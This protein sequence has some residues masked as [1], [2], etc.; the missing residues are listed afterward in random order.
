MCG[1]DVPSRCLPR[2]GEGRKC[3]AILYTVLFY[4]AFAGL[5]A[6]GGYLVGGTWESATVRN[7]TVSLSPLYETAIGC[8]EPRFCCARASCPEH[9]SP[10]K[11]ACAYDA[12]G[13]APEVGA[14]CDAAG[15]GTGVGRWVDCCARRSYTEIE[16][17]A[18][19]L[20]IQWESPEDGRFSTSYVYTDRKAR[21][22]SDA[23]RAGELL[24]TEY[25]R[26]ATA[27]YWGYTTPVENPEMEVG[28]EGWDRLPLAIVMIVFGAFSLFAA[29]VCH[30]ACRPHFLCCLYDV[31][32]CANCLAACGRACF[33]ICCPTCCTGCLVCGRG[34]C[35][36]CLDAGNTLAKAGVDT[37]IA[38][39]AVG[40]ASTAAACKHMH[41]DVS[42]DKAERRKL[43]QA[44]LD[45]E[46]RNRI[47]RYYMRNP[48]TM[49]AETSAA[50]I[51]ADA[52]RD[53]TEN[54][55]GKGGDAV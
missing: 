26:G 21:N 5:G 31:P 42:G 24:A 52:R 29:C 35:H 44:Y 3:R 1:L 50:R 45:Q 30:N 16:F 41:D 17:S 10:D 20:R 48:E 34:C 53:A 7:T 39:G 54:M 14:Q 47:T 8:V 2:D 51:E 40:A 36:A 4:A 11:A 43:V 27:Y 15:D 49:R 37:G 18:P 55:G 28:E 12:A 13:G 33:C 38:V 9:V 25:P 46:R 6:G 23:L 19:L 22:A 32:V